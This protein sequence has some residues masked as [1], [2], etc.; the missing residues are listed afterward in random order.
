MANIRKSF[1][2]RSGLQVDND[3]FVINSNGLVGIGTSVPSDYLLN[4]YGDSRVTGLVTASNAYLTQNLEVIGDTTLDYVSANNAQIGAALTVAQLQVG[5]SELVDNIIGYARTTFITDNGGVGF[6]T[7]SKL[8]IN[9]TISPGASDPEFSV[10][11]DVNVTGLVTAT[12]FNGSL[13]AANL[14]G[15]IDNARLPEIISVTDITATTFNGDLNGDA[16]G[17][18]GNAIIRV[19]DVTS[20]NINNS[21]NIT[22]ANI[23]ISGIATIST[24]ETTNIDNS[25]TISS[26][27]ITASDSIGIGTDDTTYEQ[28]IRRS[29]KSILKITSDQNE[30]II[31]IGRSTSYTDT[32]NNNALIK[33]GNVTGAY[34]YSSSDSLDIINQGNGNFNSYID[35][36]G[37]NNYFMWLRGSNNPLMTLTRS[38]NLGI[39]IT[40]PSHKLSVQGISTFSGNAYFNSNITLDGNLILTSGSFTGNV[41]GD[42][43]GNVTALTGTS[44]FN[45]VTGAAA[46]FT[47]LNVDTDDA[48][49]GANIG[50]GTTAPN[51]AVDF[52]NAGVVQ[53]RFIIP[54]KVSTTERDDF[55]ITLTE[56]AL[57]Y[58][59]TNQRLELYNGTSWVGI[60]TVA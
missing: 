50:V 9:T 53:K 56:G 51:S 10:Y 16:T 38:G 42:V 6:H 36:N 44:S 17:L 33:F 30:S 19:D 26:P 34:V 52:E 39:G 22:S 8:G 4:V 49:F 48:I 2:F 40:N 21:G 15:T 12:T 37:V 47:S 27:S 60:A 57:I 5:S 23:N 58:N 18:T 35:N 55:S 28:H 3:N 11:G 59:V 7:T 20:S 31:A 13:D 45:D 25:S 1:N 24:L 46:T 14:T 32:N 43:T 54:P 41:T 29:D